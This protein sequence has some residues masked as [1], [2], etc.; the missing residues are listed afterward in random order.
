MAGKMAQP[1]LDGRHRDQ[2]GRI[3]RK[4]GNTLLTSLRDTYGSHFAPEFPTSTTLR[5]LLTT[6]TV[7]SL[8]AFVRGYLDT[9]TGGPTLLTSPAGRRT[10]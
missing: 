6:E 8:S 4:H 10:C 7:G 9:R 1:G 2:D 5:T 3:S